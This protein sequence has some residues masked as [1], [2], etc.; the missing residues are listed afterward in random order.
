VAERARQETHYACQVSANAGRKSDALHVDV[1]M[2]RCEMGSQEAASA[3]VTAGILSWP[4]KPG[5]AAG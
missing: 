2:H 4:G 3:I 1:E 5:L